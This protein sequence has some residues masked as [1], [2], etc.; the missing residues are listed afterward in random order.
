MTGT[1]LTFTRIHVGV[2]GPREEPYAVIV[3][4]FDGERICAR[5]EGELAWLRIGAPVRLEGEAGG[6]GHRR[7]VSA[8]SDGPGAIPG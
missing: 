1:V 6:D 5:A 3:A 7:L 2:E 4:D 8:R